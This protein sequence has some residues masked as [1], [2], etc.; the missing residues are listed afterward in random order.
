MCVLLYI[1]HKDGVDLDKFHTALSLQNHRGPDDFGVY[2]AKRPESALEDA[3]KYSSSRPFLAVGHKRLSII[4]LSTQSRQPVVNHKKRTFMS[5]NGE[6]YNFM[7][8]ASNSTSQSDTLTL[9]ELLNTNYVNCLDSLNGMW[10]IIFGD[11]NKGENN[12]LQG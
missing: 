7:D 6:I 3:R 8:F 2:V 11:L 10:G 1:N 5:Y 12:I 9:F 4:D